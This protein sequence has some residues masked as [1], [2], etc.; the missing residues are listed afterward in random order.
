[1]RP[2]IRPAHVFTRLVI[3]VGFGA[4]MV[5]KTL[6]F[7]FCGFGYCFDS[8]TFTQKSAYVYIYRYIAYRILD[9]YISIYRNSAWPSPSPSLFLSLSM[10]TY[11]VGCYLSIIVPLLLIPSWHGPG[12]GAL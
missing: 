12:P 11:E 6:F 8:L 7:Y 2:E 4:A 9:I 5:V 10:Y 3:W 1:M